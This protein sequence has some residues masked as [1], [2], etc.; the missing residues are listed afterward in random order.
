M[1]LIIDDAVIGAV[2]AHMNDDHTDDSLLIA[3][4]FG[5]P[6]ATSSVMTSLDA[7]GGTWRV[8]DLKGEH[9]LTLDWPGG[10]VTERA[11]IRR[12]VVMI[13]RAACRMLDVPAREEHAPA[14]GAHAPAHAAHTPAHHAPA[15]ASHAPA[16]G[17]HVPVAAQD[18]GFAHRLRTATWGDH[19][20][21]EGA[22]FMADL[23]RGKGTLD[24]YT[25]LV[26]QHF[27]MYEALET[28][29]RQLVDDP[30]L[31]A[32]HPPALWRLAALERDL[33]HLLGDDWRNRITPAPATAAY[34]QRIVEAGDAGW[35]AGI[36]AHHYTRYL[37]DLSGG[38]V[39]ARRMVKQ[40]GFDA[41]GIAFYDF[42]ELGDLDAFKA[43]YRRVL[44]EFGATL[45]ETEQQRMLDEVRDA[46]RFN[47]A[48]FVDLGR[49]RAAA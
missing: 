33:A 32:L 22:D 17:A 48:V 27:F 11:Q 1:S 29:A 43:V 24:D 9:T 21:S 16:H 4:A 7:H 8:T 31:A 46:Y 35:T 18:E 45:T 15:R 26:A 20:D 5:H 42:T 40:F 36:I 38:Q 37:G 30:R 19:G 39:I 3:R 41:D 23:M 6:G 13:Y 47:T 44:D 12:E 14:H 2:T 28:A 25:E 49:Q 10:E 34:A